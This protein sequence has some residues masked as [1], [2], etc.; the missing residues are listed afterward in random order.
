MHALRTI[1]ATVF[2]IAVFQ[3]K[4]SHRFYKDY[5]GVFMTAEKLRNNLVC[6]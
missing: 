4:R 2:S 5:I 1:I 3:V 6:E